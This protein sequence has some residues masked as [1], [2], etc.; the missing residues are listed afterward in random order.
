MVPMI[1]E[2]FACLRVGKD[3]QAIS[4]QGKPRQQLC[5]LCGCCQQLAGRHWVGANG[6][7]YHRAHVDAKAI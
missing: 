4:V 2:V 6:F 7:A 3:D 1:W 5:E